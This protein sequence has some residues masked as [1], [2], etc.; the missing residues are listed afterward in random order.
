MT[1]SVKAKAVP[2]DKKLARQVKKAKSLPG[3]ASA[4]M[5]KTERITTMNE[6][7]TASKS[8]DE[9]NDFVKSGRT[10]ITADVISRSSS[11]AKRVI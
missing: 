10:A 3:R 6:I 5:T 2:K 8:N 7:P 11:I 9:R 4:P 1:K